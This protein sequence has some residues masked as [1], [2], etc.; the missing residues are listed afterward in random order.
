MP[1]LP[2]CSLA[3]SR[4]AAPCPLC[5]PW[6]VHPL[7][8]AISAVRTFSLRF[9]AGNVWCIRATEPW[10]APR[11]QSEAALWPRGPQHTQAG[12]GR[13]S[14]CTGPTLLLQRTAAAA[15]GRGARASVDALRCSAVLPHPPALPSLPCRRCAPIPWRPAPVLPLCLRR[16]ASGRQGRMGDAKPHSPSAPIP[17]K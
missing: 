5:A 11:P 12:R 2:R 13:H 14:L 15:A 3:H 7:R 10:R 17:I 4:C 16:S 6:F 1:V 8:C 9:P